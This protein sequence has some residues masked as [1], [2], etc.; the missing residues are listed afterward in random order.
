MGKTY[1]EQLEL[2]KEVQTA[3]EQVTVG[4]T[5][6]HYKG[7]DKIYKVLGLGFIEETTELC[8]IYQAQYEERLTFLRPV[9][10]WLETVEWEEK[11][12]PRFTKL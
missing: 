11:T 4:A 2:A 6:H 5:Y 8:V 7:K 10:V 9:S 3:G 1:K 12:V